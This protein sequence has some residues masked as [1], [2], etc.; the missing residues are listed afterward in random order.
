MCA[1]VSL[2]TPVPCSPLVSAPGSSVSLL[3]TSQAV[4]GQYRS[5]SCH[6]V[7]KSVQHTRS[8]YICNKNRYCYVRVMLTSKFD[9]HMPFVCVCSLCMSADLCKSALYLEIRK[10]FHFRVSLYVK[11]FIIIIMIF[12]LC[13]IDL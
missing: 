3:L 5:R 11:G 9:S 1:C 6:L 4:P 12:F 10:L 13:F 8:M 7:E 2:A